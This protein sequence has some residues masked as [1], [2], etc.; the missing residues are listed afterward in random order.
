M[1][2]VS[3]EAMER[4]LGIGFHLLKNGTQVLAHIG[5]AFQWQPLTL[6]HRLV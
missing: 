4:G 5:M 2:A 6:A 3:G 1:P